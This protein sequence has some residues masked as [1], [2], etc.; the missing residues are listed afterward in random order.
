MSSVQEDQLLSSPKLLER[1][2]SAI[3]GEIQALV[4]DVQRV[5]SDFERFRDQ[6]NSKPSELDLI[7][8]RFETAWEAVSQNTLNIHELENRLAG[9]E[10][11]RNQ[12]RDKVSGFEN[13]LSD[14]SDRMETTEK[15]VRELENRLAGL[16]SERN[17]T[18]DK[19]SGFENSLSDASDRMETTEKL[20]RELEN[21]LAGLESERNQ[22]RDKVSGFEN[23]LS[24]ASDRME[25]TEKL[26]RALED[27]LISQ[28]QDYMN[29]FQDMLMRYRKQHLRIN[30]TMS[31]TGIAL[32]LGSVSVVIMVWD[33]QRN[34]TRL[35]SMTKVLKS[36]SGSIEEHLSLQHK[37]QE[38]K[39]QLTLPETPHT[40]PET[41]ATA[42][43]EK[44]KNSKK[45]TL[46]IDNSYPP[47]N[48]MYR[49]Y[50]SRDDHR[51]P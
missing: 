35:S 39:Q 37:P 34:A 49:L 16:E 6:E 45:R 46:R 32:L 19:V 41:K 4:N 43:P 9:L 21:R 30:W 50:Q 10:S 12:T 3:D 1:E 40:A 14:A 44:P 42:Q 20:V 23:S 24:D 51:K 33:V 48:L 38:E 8:S 7:N 18:R 28:H 25:T 11:E 26:V 15:L 2:I 5:R 13:S 36:L 17:Q 29:T 27:G 22:T 47:D 31:F